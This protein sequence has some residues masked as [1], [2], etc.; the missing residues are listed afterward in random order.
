L[1]DELVDDDFSL[2]GLE[3][4]ELEDELLASAEVDEAGAFGF[5]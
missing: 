4:F 1:L 5:T 2:A 3:P